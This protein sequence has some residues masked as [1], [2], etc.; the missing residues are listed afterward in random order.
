RVAKSRTSSTSSPGRWRSGWTT[1]RRRRS[2]AAT[3]SRYLR[4]TTP[5]SSATSLSSALTSRPAATTRSRGAETERARPGPRR[6]LCG[7]KR[8]NTDETDE[9]GWSRIESVFIRLI[10]LI[11]VPSRVT[12]VSTRFGNG[13]LVPAVVALANL[14]GVERR[15]ARARERAYSSALVPAGD[16][17]DQSAAERAAGHRQLVAVLLPEGAGRR[18]AVGVEVRLA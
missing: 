9:D 13:F 11:R 1:A 5:G 17:A 2:G 8:E 10:R 3:W 6:R 7:V 18:G 15:A 12:H 4:A 16:A 14:V